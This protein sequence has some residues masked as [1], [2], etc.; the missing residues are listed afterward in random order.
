MKE[1]ELRKQLLE[2]GLTSRRLSNSRQ[3]SP[4]STVDGGCKNGSD[5]VKADCDLCRCD[6]SEKLCF[7]SM[8]YYLRLKFLAKP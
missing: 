1:L 5:D 3:D 2:L 4:S 6:V 7:L 8:V